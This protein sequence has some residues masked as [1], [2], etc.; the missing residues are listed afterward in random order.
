MIICPQWPATL[1]S[2]RL[3]HVSGTEAALTGTRRP[4]ELLGA[5]GR[6]RFHVCRD[7]CP[8]DCVGSLRQAICRKFVLHVRLSSASN[9]RSDH[10]L[11]N[12]LHAPQVLESLFVEHVDIEL[13]HDLNNDVQ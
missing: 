3:W 2:A 5:P 1:Q 12:T 8:G 4:S 11:L 13:F 7:V 10:A 9:G 6:R